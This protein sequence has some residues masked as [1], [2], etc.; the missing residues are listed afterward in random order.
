MWPPL[1]L[2]M[3][4]QVTPLP[5]LPTVATHQS[6]IPPLSVLAVNALRRCDPGLALSGS[7]HAP[8]GLH[9]DGCKFRV[10]AAFVQCVKQAS[11]TKR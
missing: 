11:M 10:T 9:A 4:L 7:A 1:L 8:T 2:A 5:G 6:V 3:H